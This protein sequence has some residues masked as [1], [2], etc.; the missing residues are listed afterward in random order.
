MV[1]L[2]VEQVLTEFTNPSHTNTHVRTQATSVIEPI[3]TESPSQCSIAPANDPLSSQMC[4]G[5]SSLLQS[6][7]PT[8]VRCVLT[9]TSIGASN[10]TAS[11]DIADKG[12]V[13]DVPPMS[14][15]DSSVLEALPA[16]IKEKILIEYANKQAKKT[17][18]GPAHEPVTTLMENPSSPKHTQDLVIALTEQ[19]DVEQCVEKSVSTVVSSIM[20]TV[21]IE[22]E[23]TFIKEIRSYLREWILN[24]L[25]GPTVDDMHMVSDYFLK[26]THSNLNVTSLSL[27]S[28]RRFIAD[29]ELLDWF[30]AFNE[31]LS[32]V[33]LRVTSEYGGKLSIPSL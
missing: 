15:L 9:D 21:I 25:D 12:F 7:H 10:M 13:I 26:L 32:V 11:S 29:L 27:K 17:S 2:V 31:L 28:M 6:A 30:A 19:G 20:H 24:C 8:P 22:N 33:Q 23:S 16:Y 4:Q 3:S 5:P 14:Q 1:L 18:S